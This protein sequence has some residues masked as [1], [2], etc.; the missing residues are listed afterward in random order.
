M[1]EKGLS[2]AS[3]QAA[4]ARAI[5]LILEIAGGSVASEIIDERA[6]EYQ[7]LIFPFSPQKARDLMGVDVSDEDQIALLEDLGFTLQRTGDQYQVTVPYWRDHDIE[8]SVDLTEEVARMFG[9][10]NI[11]SRIPKGEI[12]LQVKDNHLIWEE[13]LRQELRASGYTEFFSYSFTGKDAFEKYDLDAEKA[14]ALFNPLSSE[15]THMRTSLIPSLLMSVEDNQGKTPS[16]KVFEIARIYL[17]NAGDLPE[18]KSRMYIAHYGVEDAQYAFQALKGVLEQ[19]ERRTGIDLTLVRETDNPHWHPTRSAKVLHGDRVIGIFGQVADEYQAAFGIDKPVFVIDIDIEALI[20]S[21]KEVSSYTEASD[22]PA[23]RRDLSILV[24]RKA[25]FAD[26]GSAMKK[27]TPMIEEI[28]LVEVYRGK[29][30][31]EGKKSM[32]FGI[33]FRAP[34]KTLSAEMVEGIMEAI[35]DEL[36]ATFHAVM[37]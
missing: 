6:E 7:L 22:F 26:I 15:L 1:F 2:T 33:R 32:T 34:D 35:I 37:R 24:D 17:P 12:P 5:E 25:T 28:D 8:H 29:G 30:I 31:P 27:C 23:V 18:E 10:H 3:V 21:M 19:I 9:Y 11:P 16:G 14:V 36:R 4:M 20:P 13:W